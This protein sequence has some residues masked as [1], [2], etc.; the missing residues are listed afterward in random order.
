MKRS[1]QNRTV[2][3]LT[4]CLGFALAP[5]MLVGCEQNDA[6]DKIEEVGDSIEDAADDAADAVEDTVEEIDDP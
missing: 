5:A 1:A 3:T 6:E 4:A 2:P